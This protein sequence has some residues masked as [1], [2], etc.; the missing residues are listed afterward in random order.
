VDVL[1]VEGDEVAGSRQLVPHSAEIRLMKTTTQGV[2]HPSGP[3]GIS[4]LPVEAGV[5]EWIPGG[6]RNF[7]R[8][9][10]IH[11]AADATLHVAPK[12]FRVILGPKKAK[13]ARDICA[14]MQTRSKTQTGT[15]KFFEVTT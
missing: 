10:K 4:F 13:V 9:V 2:E 6:A 7:E 11:C 5:K 12:I 15:L 8:K 3:G 14:W 1:R